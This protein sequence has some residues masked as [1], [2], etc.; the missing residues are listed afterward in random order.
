LACA[1]LNA[2][3]RM[4]CHYLVETMESEWEFDIG[5]PER[6]IEVVP[7]EQPMPPFAP[8]DEPVK[9]PERIP[10]KVPV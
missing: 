4:I 6:K 1:R 3:V 5:E 2:I 7:L 8:D 10:D 9:N